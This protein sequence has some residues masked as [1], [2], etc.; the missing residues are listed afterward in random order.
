VDERLEAVNTTPW[1]RVPNDPENYDSEYANRGD[2]PTPAPIDPATGQHKTYWVL[3][4]EER[5]KGF[6]RPYRETYIHLTCGAVTK[7]SRSIAETYARNPKYYGATFCV[8][9]RDHFPVGEDGQFKWEDGS[10]VG[11]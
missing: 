1:D 4:E 11:A 7:M 6:V 8:H 9:C 3:P 2:T 5:A 10:M